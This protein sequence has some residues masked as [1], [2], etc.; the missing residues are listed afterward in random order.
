[1]Y[2]KKIKIKT[3]FMRNIDIIFILLIMLSIFL[4][5][6][7][8][9]VELYGN[10]SK[11]GQVF[12]VLLIM[13]IYLFI[14]LFFKNKNI[15]ALFLIDII[16]SLI[17]LP[18]VIF[19][20][21]YGD[22][23]T[24]DLI[25]QLQ[26][27]SN[28]KS[29]IIQLVK[30]KDVLYIVDI[31]IILNILF[32]KN[33]KRF[34][35][36]FHVKNKLMLFFVNTILIILCFGYINKESHELL[37]SEYS[38]QEIE[39]EMGFVGLYLVDGYNYF[40]NNF[41]IKDI[42]QKDIDN[43]NSQLLT[44]KFTDGKYKNSNL[45]VIQVESLQQF[46]I[47]K[48]YNGKE[49]TPYLNKLIKDSSYFENCY[50]QIGLGHTADAELLTNTSMYPL[51]NAC[52]YVSKSNNEYFSLAKSLDSLGYDSFA[53]HGNNASF[54]NREVMYKTLGFNKF[55]SLENLKKDD[56]I[57][58][59]IS[60]ESLFKQS[61]DIITNRKQ[62]FYAFYV[63]LTSHSTFDIENDFSNG[64][65]IISKYYNA[66]NYTDKSIGEFLE[67][68]KEKGILDNSV[69]VIY[70]D[71]NAITLD[72]KSDFEK[73]IT[74]QEFTDA[75][76]QAYQKVPMILRLPNGENKGIYS[77]SVGQIDM[78]PTV[79]NLLG[80][81][82]SIH[83]GHDMLGNNDNLVVLKDGSYI[84][85]NEFYNS[86]QNVTYDINNGNVLINNQKRIS[87]AMNQ[88]KA[89]DDIYKYNYLKNI[90]QD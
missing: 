27:A 54:Y 82:N 49:V 89:S 71:H 79:N 90:E 4:K 19:Y 9:S 31:P 20:R 26:E 36:V 37:M 42:S 6:L 83:F 28:E 30:F 86:K 85:G 16:V 18:N 58:G 44:T 81:N 7:Y 12:N 69:L 50:Y 87:E 77:K 14:Q 55:Y 60:D 3:Y 51:K 48:T 88:L 2:L 72:N 64:N 45:I 41:Y 74:K 24:F 53:F 34:R 39:K 29:S 61:L 38:R 76:W 22:F 84:F 62:P 15:K 43:I 17:I 13:Y 10:F 33:K 70:G 1:M 67:K 68:L 78:L 57:S 35:S 63:T 75:S 23:I 59:G 5:S 25:R 66:I 56:L 73:E 21:Y 52:A 40:V 32:L 47:N 46:V 80:I 65:D 8:A 11:R